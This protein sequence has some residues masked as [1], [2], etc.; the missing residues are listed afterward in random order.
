MKNPPERR[1][2][3]YEVG[4]RDWR[5][6]HKLSPDTDSLVTTVRML[7]SAGLERIEI[8]ASVNY[9]RF[10]E[11]RDTYE[12]LR[13]L[14]AGRQT[15]RYGI[16]VG[17]G[18]E[19]YPAAKIRE[20]LERGVL[21]DDPGLPDEICVSISA[22]EER[23]HEIY[24]MSGNKVFD[25]VQRQVE[26]ALEDGMR[27]RGY[28][29]AAFGGYRD[30]LDAPISSAIGWCQLLFDIGCYEVA[31]GDTRG[32]AEPGQF[33]RTWDMMKNFLPMERIAL[34]IHAHW[35]VNW[36]FDLMHVVRD[37][38]NT[39]DTSVFDIPEPSTH[40]HDDLLPFDLTIPP[41][42][43]TQKMVSFVNQL[44]WEI[45]ARERAKMGTRRLTTGVDFE[46]VRD[47]VSFIRGVIQQQ[48]QIA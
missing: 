27:V 7:E 6:S 4:F 23:N 14:R 22:S 5:F 43:S 2:N 8:G 21:E 39:F 48:Q 20:L 10:P 19:N 24:N 44:N 30:T 26:K 45:P 1:I 11:V 38:V 13:R 9:E 47:A 40:S 35:Y 15:A 12:I 41:N 25:Y 34:H 3:L 28:V 37:G 31:L 17:P 18:A 29:S 36:E 32:K 16:Y 33:K 46:K 42:A